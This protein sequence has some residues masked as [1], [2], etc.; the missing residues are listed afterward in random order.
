LNSAVAQRDRIIASPLAP[1]C[2]ELV[3]P[4]AHEYLSGKSDVRDPDH[5]APQKSMKRAE[6]YTLL[7]RAGGSDAVLAR[8]RRE[9]GEAISRE[10]TGAGETRL[11]QQVSDFEDAIH[12]RHR[13]CMVMCIG[14]TPSDVQAAYEAAEQ[15]AV[16]HNLLSASIGRAATGSSAFAF[17]PLGVDPPNAMQFANAASALR[18]RLP[19]GS[20][21]IAVRCP[22]ETKERFDVWGSSANDMDL[23]RAVREAMDPKGILN[24]GRFVV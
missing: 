3:S 14:V 16:E 1:M 18:S 4:R 17:V 19:K 5:Y 7:V 6:A 22:P 21:A 9:L 10:V 11:W 24:R 23:M 8:C 15:S 2:M 12:N 13:N 20:V